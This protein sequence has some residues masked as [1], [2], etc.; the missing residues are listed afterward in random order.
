MKNFSAIKSF[1]DYWR[2]REDFEVSPVG[3]CVFPA[4][5]TYEFRGTSVE[6]KTRCRITRNGYED[7]KVSLDEAGP[8]VAEVF[9]LDFSPDLQAYSYDMKSHAFIVEGKSAKMV[10]SYRVVIEP[11]F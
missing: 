9:H 4:L 11:I 8:L 2:D 1:V 6:H 3:L 5:V 7:G 10:G